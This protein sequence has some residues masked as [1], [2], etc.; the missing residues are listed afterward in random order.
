MF[1]A[2]STHKT[3]KNKESA[4]DLNQEVVYTLIFILLT[5]ALLFPIP[6]SINQIS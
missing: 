4:K 1:S 2:Q 5:P 6:S 3:E